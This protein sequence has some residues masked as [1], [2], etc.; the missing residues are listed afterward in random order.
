MNQITTVL[1]TLESEISRYDFQ[2]AVDFFE[3]D[4]HIRKFPTKQMFS[5]LVFGQLT[6]GFSI[7]EIQHS[8]EA[9]S[10]RLYHNGLSAIKR[11]TFADAL[12]KR[13]YRIFVTLHEQ[14]LETA[15]AISGRKK[16]RFENPL[17]V[18][19]ST[20]IEVNVN[21]FP[22]AKFR[23]TKGGIKLHVS[24]D[25]ETA[26]IEQLAFTDGK[27]HD[28]NRFAALSHQPGVIYVADRAY[29]DFK[30]L[31]R[32]E[33]NGGYF[34]TRAKKNARFQVE[35]M[36]S[37]NQNGPVR[38]DCRVTLTGPQTKKD[39]SRPLRV[40]E[41]YDEAKEHVFAF[42]TND[43]SHTAQEIADMYK[44]RWEIELFFK[45]L[46]QNLKIK[47]FW[48]TSR[49]AVLTQIWV[50]L[51]VYLLIWIMKMKNMVDYSLQRIRQI[52]KT[53]LL[54]KIALESLLRPP[55]K[56]SPMT[57]EPYIFETVL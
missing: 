55:P 43:F 13:D 23:Q 25:P 16:R 42:L 5:G 54:D 44:E 57:P 51:I 22:W 19:D 37:Q 24:Y 52:L 8:L 38:R 18:I 26:L 9:N 46:K 36:F 4:K 45:W 1:R 40:V 20:M 48:G 7:R 30:S 53:T 56:P 29:C 47:T 11:S 32:I 41:Y 14:L 33:I 15:L 17:R 3:G 31:Y 28:C 50:A 12:A 27:V 10:H 39:Y 21:R 2:K 49:N 6:N 34:V 35:E